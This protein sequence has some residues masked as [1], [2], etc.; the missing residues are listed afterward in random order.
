MGIHVPGLG[1][2][3]YISFRAGMAVLFSLTI[4][5]VY[6]KRIINYLR[7]KQMGELVRDLGLDGQKQ[8]EGTP[9]MG[10]LIIHFG[11]VN[12]CFA[13]YQNYKRLYCSSDC[14]RDMDGCNWFSG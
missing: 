6:G 2:L 5:L 7:A 14:F 13:I 10:G 1:L 3:K 12:S 9:T 4:A 8:K 11:N